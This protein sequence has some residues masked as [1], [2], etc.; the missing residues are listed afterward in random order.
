MKIDGAICL[1]IRGH[2]IP[3]LL[4][5]R[6]STE[7]QGIDKTRITTPNTV[8][9]NTLYY[10]TLDPSGSRKQLFC[11]EAV[12][13]VTCVKKTVYE[14]VNDG[15]LPCGCYHRNATTSLR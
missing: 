10:G 12:P 5:Q 11:G 7:K 13:E 15:S 1:R 6:P 3:Q 9:L 14:G 2:D 4:A 8:P